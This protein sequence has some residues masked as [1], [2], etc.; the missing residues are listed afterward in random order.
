MKKLDYLKLY[1]DEMNAIEFLSDI[2]AGRVIKSVVKY[3]RTGSLPHTSDDVVQT[4]FERIKNKIDKDRKEY[5]ALCRQYSENAKKRY[6]KSAKNSVKMPCNGELSQPVESASDIVPTM[7][8]S[9][10]PEKNEITTDTQDDTS[11]DRLWTV[12]NHPKSD[13]HRAELMW[14]I[15]SKDEKR[16]AIAYIPKF[17]N[18]HSK[19][20]YLPYLALYLTEKPWQCDGN[21]K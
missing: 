13:R 21:K 18:E 2:V 16:A 1:S 14:S 3:A 20:S 8:I 7:T 6:E 5:Y 4:L 9:Q 19:D 10:A 12:Y 15:F 11:F 17:K